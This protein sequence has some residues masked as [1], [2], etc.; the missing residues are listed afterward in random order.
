MEYEVCL[1]DL[2]MALKMGADE[3]LLKFDSQLVTLQ[4]K[5]DCH[6]NYLIIQ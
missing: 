6:A 5:N 1:V 2:Q 3:V 4:I